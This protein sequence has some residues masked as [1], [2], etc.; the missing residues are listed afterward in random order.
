MKEAAE[1]EEWTDFRDKELWEIEVAEL[2][3][4]PKR[5]VL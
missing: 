4:S 3:C 5:N 1:K 2:C